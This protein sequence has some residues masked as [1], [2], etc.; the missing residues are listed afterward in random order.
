MVRDGSSGVVEVMETIRVQVVSFSHATIRQSRQKHHQ[1]THMKITHLLEIKRRSL[2][3]ST[4]ILNSSLS[5]LPNNPNRS[6]YNDY[7]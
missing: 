6:R 7:Q 5:Y 4:F 1:K 2:P 3:F